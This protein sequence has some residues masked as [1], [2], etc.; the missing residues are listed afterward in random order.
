MK[1][2]T[3]NYRKHKRPDGWGTLRPSM[4]Q[5]EAQK[6]LGDSVQSGKARYNVC[7]EYCY[8]S[9]SHD[10]DEMGETLWHGFPIKWSDLPT[11][12]KNLLIA[13][14]RLTNKQYKK[15]LRKPLEL[16]FGS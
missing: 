10:T 8:K 16:E 2:D 9:F 3:S 1:Y 5:D 6:L 14:G 15:A 11:E 4:T 7:D 12:A 13:K